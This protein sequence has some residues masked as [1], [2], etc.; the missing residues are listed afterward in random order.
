MAF[1]SVSQ[2]PERDLGPVFVC[3]ASFSTET[4]EGLDSGI[5]LIAFQ[6]PLP[7]SGSLLVLD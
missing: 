1:L 5:F 7:L 2:P 6:G 3:P 4:Q